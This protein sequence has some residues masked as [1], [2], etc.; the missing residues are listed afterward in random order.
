MDW[1]FSYLVLPPYWK[2]ILT[3]RY[4]EVLKTSPSS[5]LETC[6]DLLL[7]EVLI[8]C[9]FSL[10]ETYFILSIPEV[11]TYGPSSVQEVSVY[12]SLY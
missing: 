12:S 2:N 1:K 8:S 5:L 4:A 11:L 6:V 7:F 9:P 10:L 3:F